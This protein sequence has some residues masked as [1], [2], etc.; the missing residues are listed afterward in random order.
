M[1]IFRRGNGLFLDNHA[2]AGMPAGEAVRGAS[3]AIS[4]N[5]VVYNA[6]RLCLEGHSCIPVTDRT[7]KEFRGLVTSRNLLD[8]LGGGDLNQM[9]VSRKD[10]MKTPV[11]KVMETDIIEMGRACTLGEALSVFKRT[12]EEVIP[13]VEKGRLDGVIRES[14][15]VRHIAG[16]TGVK[17]WELMT[18]KPV[19]ARTIHPVS[20]VAGMIARGGYRR[21]PVVRDG[22]LTGIVGASDILRYLKKNGSM[23]SLK[24]DRGEIQNAM[25]KLVQSVPPGADVFD[26][27][28]IMSEK[29]VCILPVVDHYQLIGVLTHRDIID[30]M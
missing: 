22:F 18:S 15:I 16:S 3:H 8:L 20:E 7:G 29:G 19:V 17:V 27:A 5:D 9:F 4:E 25:N 2:D 21:L 13:L 1:G 14:D 23:L 24:R 10:G 12:G 6:L 11:S 26:A 30:S 28:R